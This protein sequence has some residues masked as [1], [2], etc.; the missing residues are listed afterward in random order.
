MTHDMTQHEPYIIKQHVTIGQVC[1][2][3]QHDNMTTGQVRSEGLVSSG[4]DRKE[5]VLIKLTSVRLSGVEP[6]TLSE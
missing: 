4:Q 2:E 1:S 6:N 5:I 3:G